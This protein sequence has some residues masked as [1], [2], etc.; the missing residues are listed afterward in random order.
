VGEPA[1]DDSVHCDRHGPA[2]V[3]FVCRHLVHGSGLGFWHS[4]NGP[5]P[6]AWCGECDAV[7]MRAGRWTARAERFAGITLVCNRCY[8][9]IRRR[10][11]V[12]RG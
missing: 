8:A 2:R 10:N 4:D 11:R 7:M 3:A 1:D 6:D 9:N 12:R 5:C